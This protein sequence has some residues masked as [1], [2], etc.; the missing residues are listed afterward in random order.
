MPPSCSRL[1]KPTP[2]HPVLGTPLAL[3]S[4]L[5][6]L[7]PSP[8]SPPN[9]SAIGTSGREKPVQ[10]WVARGRRKSIYLS[11]YLYREREKESV[12]VYIVH[13]EKCRSISLSLSL[14][15]YI[16]TYV[17][18][19]IYTHIHIYIYMRARP[20]PPGSTIIGGSREWGEHAYS[21]T[22]AVTGRKSL[23]ALL[24]CTV[25]DV[26]SSTVFSC[27]LS[28]LYVRPLD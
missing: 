10:F 27:I 22:E 20:P 9:T 21:A 3:I 14:S 24:L 15:L 12:Y 17:Y 23:A 26:V 2:S 8:L 11:I 5:P 6:A 19:C 7:P 18:I 25:C 28:S 16:Y 1:P 13:T 4:A